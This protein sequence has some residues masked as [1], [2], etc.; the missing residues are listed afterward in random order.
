MYSSGF[1]RSDIPAGQPRGSPS[2]KR[3]AA[4]GALGP[5]RQDLAR[6]AGRGR[7]NLTNIRSPHFGTAS[8]AAVRR[9][10]GRRGRPT[11]EK[12]TKYRLPDPGRTPPE[13]QLSQNLLTNTE[14]TDS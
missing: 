9:R 3:L 10:G 14:Y 6:G 11:S 8:P 5:D 12:P 7:P 2:E 4:S 1:G 13:P